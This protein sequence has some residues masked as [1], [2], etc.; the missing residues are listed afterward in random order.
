[1]E[2]E[3]PS[4]CATVNCNWCEG[5]IALCYLCKCNY[6]TQLLIN[7]II[8]TRTRLIS[9]LHVTILKMLLV[10]L[11]ILYISPDIYTGFALG[12]LIP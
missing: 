6:V 8:R 1:V 4:A 10:M 7:P 2:T 12:P 9:D 3:N 5:E 11:P